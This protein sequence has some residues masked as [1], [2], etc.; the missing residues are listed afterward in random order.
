MIVYDLD[1]EAE[2]Q[3]KPEDFVPERFHLKLA[4]GEMT[5]A[6]FQMMVRVFAPPD[7]FPELFSKEEVQA[8][9]KKE[10]EKKKKKQPSRR[11][12]N[13]VGGERPPQYDYEKIVALWKEGRTEPGT[14]RPC[15]EIAAIMG[16]SPRTVT[17]ALKKL[18]PEGYKGTPGP[19]P[20]R[21]CSKGH[22]MAVHGKVIKATGHRY[23]G[24][25]RRDRERE[26]WH[27]NRKHKRNG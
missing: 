11:G 25:C 6:S 21:V 14:L 26:Q 13:L 10:R 22:D 8:A 5:E 20:P 4:R 19:P 23:C 16:C 18:K 3:P 9:K 24:Q 17:A 1:E 12:A 2:P 7:L 15:V 27:T